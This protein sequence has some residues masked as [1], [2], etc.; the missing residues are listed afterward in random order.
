ML[1]RSLNKCGSVLYTDKVMMFLRTDNIRSCSIAKFPTAEAS[2]LVL[3]FFYSIFVIK[4]LQ[5][6]AKCKIRKLGWLLSPA[7][8]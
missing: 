6:I 8:M 7:L 2:F 1:S 5:E 4:D 3:F